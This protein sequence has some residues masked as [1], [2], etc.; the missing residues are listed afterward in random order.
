[1][2]IYTYTLVLHGVALAPPP[3]APAPNLFASWTSG[4][5]GGVSDPPSPPTPTPSLT[6]SLTPWSCLTYVACTIYYSAQRGREGGG[7]RERREETRGETWRK[8]P[9]EE[10]RERERYG[11]TQKE[12]DTKGHMAEG[13]TDTGQ[14]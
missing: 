4:K 1:M 9:R 6:P 3:C 12:R 2:Y 11:E 7:E 10:E 5:G 8:R 14:A 13:Y